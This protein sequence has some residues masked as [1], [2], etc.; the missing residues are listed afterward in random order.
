[1]SHILIIPEQVG[2]PLA[3]N[4]TYKRA[5]SSS[6]ASSFLVGGLYIYKQA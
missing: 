6:P 1:M 5:A 2:G 3:I 4:M